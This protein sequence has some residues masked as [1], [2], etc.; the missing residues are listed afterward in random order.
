MANRILNGTAKQVKRS[1]TPD[2]SCDVWH[3]LPWKQQRRYWREDMKEQCEAFVPELTEIENLLRDET[4]NEHC[5]IE[6]PE[7]HPDFTGSIAHRKTDAEILLGRLSVSLEDRFDCNKGPA[8]EIGTLLRQWA[9]GLLKAAQRIDPQ[10]ATMW[11]VVVDGKVIDREFSFELA[12]HFADTYNRMCG[13]TEAT[14]R[15][16]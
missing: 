14:I 12:E 11:E 10:P 9:A 3:K 16:A 8:A 7:T 15:S 5:Y 1:S 6:E 13:A 4:G 2:L